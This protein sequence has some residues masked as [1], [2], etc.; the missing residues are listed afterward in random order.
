MKG[1]PKDHIL[2]MGPLMKKMVQD[3]LEDHVGTTIEEVSENYV[4]RAR[5]VV[6]YMLRF[7][8]NLGEVRFKH[9]SNSFI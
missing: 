7:Q 2:K 4:E 1:I 5:A 3:F 9:R 8:E 6:Y